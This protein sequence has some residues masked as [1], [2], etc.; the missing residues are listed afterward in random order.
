LLW[1]WGNDF[2]IV[3]FTERE[4]SVSRPASGMDASERGPNAS[5]FLNELDA[6][7]EIAATEQDVIE[8]SRHFGGSPQV[9]GRCKGSASQ[10]KK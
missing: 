7:I 5:V 10:S 9:R 8:N 4:K 2:Q 6:T 3:F 1:I